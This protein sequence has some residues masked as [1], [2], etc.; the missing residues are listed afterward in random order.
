MEGDPDESGQ[1]G[2]RWVGMQLG[3]CGEDSCDQVSQSSCKA[4]EADER[5]AGLAF[6]ASVTEAMPLLWA[7]CRDPSLPG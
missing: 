1:V 7:W 2:R 5:S 3:L 4:G 6:R